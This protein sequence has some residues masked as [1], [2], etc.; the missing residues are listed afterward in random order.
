MLLHGLS[1]NSK[2]RKK[3]VLLA[4][5]SALNTTI[6]KIGTPDWGRLSE[7]MYSHTHLTPSQS[8]RE[9]ILNRVDQKKWV[10]RG[11]SGLRIG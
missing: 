10:S 3:E 4:G 2:S 6:R 9:D 8:L 5:I 7:S 1:V 11:K